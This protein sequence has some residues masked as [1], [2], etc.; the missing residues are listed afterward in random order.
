MAVGNG[1][2]M[3]NKR[4]EDIS[5]NRRHLEDAHQSIEG[6]ISVCMPNYNKGKFVYEAVRSIAEQDF[7]D[8]ELCIVDD[9]SSDDSV[10]E[11][12]RAITV[13]RDRFTDVKFLPL[14]TRT[15]YAWAQNI[16]YYLSRGE[17]IANMDSDDTCQSFRLSKQYAYMKSFD[18][19]IVGTT[20]YSINGNDSIRLPRP[21]ELTKMQ[22]GTC[23]FKRTILEKTGG[24]DKT[25]IGTE[26]Y[27]FLKKVES[28]GFRFG[29]MYEH[30][31]NY[32]VSGSQRSK[33]FHSSLV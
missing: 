8:I 14:K 13:F 32:R 19:D 4:L 15:G 18:L 16:A 31:Y 20:V 5:E 6:L 33:L 2:K 27:G 3:L 7:K 24:L 10:S 22:L 29:V 17:V 30:L 21:S 23:I 28:G 12:T 11:I 26:D 9:Q 1:T 25:F